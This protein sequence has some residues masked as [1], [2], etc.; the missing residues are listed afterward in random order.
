MS[1]KSNTKKRN[2]RNR[3]NSPEKA[4]NDLE[5]LCRTVRR[6]SAEPL[7]DLEKVALSIVMFQSRNNQ[8]PEAKPISET[9]SEELVARLSDTAKLACWRAWERRV[10]PYLLACDQSEVRDVQIRLS[11]ALGIPAS[12]FSENPFE[13]FGTLFAPARKWWMP[14][15][16]N[17]GRYYISKTPGGNDIWEEYL[18]RAE[19][20]FLHALESY[21]LIILSNPSLAAHLA[22]RD[23]FVKKIRK[24]VSDLFEYRG[25]VIRVP[26]S[27]NTDSVQMV[28]IDD[29]QLDNSYDL[30]GINDEIA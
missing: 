1:T 21:G 28:S 5:F 6:E 25:G 17:V 11:E 29:V 22:F 15:I 12:R 20:A 3:K 24:Q 30:L 8:T 7:S 13:C 18:Q 2:L 23:L 27:S 14:V 16:V 26:L 4:F 9:T 19:E 10:S